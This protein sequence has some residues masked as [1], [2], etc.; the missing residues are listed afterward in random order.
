MITSP[1]VEGTNDLMNSSRGSGTPPWLHHVGPA[2]AARAWPRPSHKQLEDLRRPSAS[3]W[4]FSFVSAARWWM[5][6]SITSPWAPKLYI[7]PWEPWG[8]LHLALHKIFLGREGN[9]VSIK[10]ASSRFPDLQPFLAGTISPTSGLQ[11]MQIRC[12]GCMAQN[13]LQLWH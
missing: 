2:M 11:I 5:D 9:L 6:G 10:S 3:S 7:C 13:F 8:M 12:P 1:N 4:C